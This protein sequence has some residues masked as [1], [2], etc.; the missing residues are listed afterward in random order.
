VNDRGAVIDFHYAAQVIKWNIN[1]EETESQK[2]EARE[3][4]RKYGEIWNLA[5]DAW[6]SACPA[7]EAISL[8]LCLQK[9]G[10]MMAERLEFQEIAKCR[11]AKSS[12]WREI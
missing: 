4:E 7:N 9:A 6:N 11:E 5:L 3:A 1:V 12:Q 8:I 10:I 2:F